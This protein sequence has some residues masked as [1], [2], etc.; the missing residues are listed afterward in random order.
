MVHRRGHGG[1][2]TVVSRDPEGEVAI[3]GVHDVTTCVMARDQI[4]R[5]AAEE[6]G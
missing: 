2:Y 6:H 5:L 4:A 3:F 1:R